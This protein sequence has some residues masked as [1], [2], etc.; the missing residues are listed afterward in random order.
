MHVLAI[1]SPYWSLNRCV[2]EIILKSY[3]DL[4]KLQFFTY[5]SVTSRALKTNL[6]LLVAVTYL[7]F[8]F[9][10]CE[11]LGYEHFALLAADIVLTHDLI[12]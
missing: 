11:L 5:W 6:L 9:Y 7:V 8:L 10:I 2:G 12:P 4:A 1:L 3:F